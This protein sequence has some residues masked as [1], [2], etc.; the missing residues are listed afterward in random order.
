M[1]RQVF[2]K[3]T[4]IIGTAPYTTPNTKY[5]ITYYTPD[6]VIVTLENQVPEIRLWGCNPTQ[7]IDAACL[8]GKSIDGGWDEDTGEL[9]WFFFEPPKI[10]PCPSQTTQP[11]G[12]SLVQ[13]PIFE[14]TRTGGQGVQG[15][16]PGAPGDQSGG[17][18]GG[19]TP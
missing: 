12:S 10:A 15:G 6:G 9:R 1:I 14:P 18:P 11:P 2:G 4:A 3:I 16:S 17:M 13:L 8:V 5:Q 19:V 7:Q